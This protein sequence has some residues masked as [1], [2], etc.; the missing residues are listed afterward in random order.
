LYPVRQIFVQ[1]LLLRAPL[2]LRGGPI[3]LGISV[4]RNAGIAALEAV[5]YVATALSITRLA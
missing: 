3:D 2:S 4:D 1:V 5:T